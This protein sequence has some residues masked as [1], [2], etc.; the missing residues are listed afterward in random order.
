[1]K[2]PQLLRVTCFVIAI[3]VFFA[4]ADGQVV[5]GTGIRQSNVGDDFE[6]P[7]WKWH[8][9]G[10]KASREQDELERRPLGGS[11]NGRWFE[12]PSEANQTSS[13][14][15]QLRKAGFQAATSR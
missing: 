14:A 11:S 4:S 12:S 2:S 9:N 15:F 1:M 8:P 7:N 13:N 10:E 3:P 6:D 5:P